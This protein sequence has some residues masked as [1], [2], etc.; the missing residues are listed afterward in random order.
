MHARRACSSLI[1]PAVLCPE[2]AQQPVMEMLLA[3]GLEGGA[4]GGVRGSGERYRERA[5]GEVELAGIYVE[6][7]GKECGGK[8]R[9]KI[10]PQ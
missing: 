9:T 7:G 5:W 3:R 4:V 1:Q 2:E 10:V 8:G 6:L